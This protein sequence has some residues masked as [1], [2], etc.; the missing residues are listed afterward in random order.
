MP[1]SRYR[2]AQFGVS[3]D[4]V[5]AAFYEA[6]RNGD[7]DQMM[8][9]WADEDEIV[10]VLPGGPR[11]VGVA[12]IRG[13]FDTMFSI[14]AVHAWP[15]RVRRVES[16]GAAIHNVL[17]RVD[18][19]TADGMRRSWVV[20]TNVYLKTAPGWRLA[21]HHASPGRAEADEVTQ[22]ARLLH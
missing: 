20:A 18:L 17:E 15:E 21:A 7:L 6:L 16:M 12:T 2:S 11:L 10:C 1:K 8:A 19:M 9:C 5:E 14:G 22:P 3:P 13:A 4:D